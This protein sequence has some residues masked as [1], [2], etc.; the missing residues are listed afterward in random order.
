MVFML[1]GRQCQL[2]RE[3]VERTMAGIQPV[4]GRSYFVNVNGEKYPVTQ[5]L[6]FSLRKQYGGLS[7][8]DI[9]NNIAKNILSQI[10]FEIIEEK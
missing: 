8:L 1:N 2:S 7:L 9:N 3:E 4:K 10:G 6:F 5:V